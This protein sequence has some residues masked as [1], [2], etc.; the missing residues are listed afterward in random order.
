[1]KSVLVV[2]DEPGIGSLVAMCLDHLDIDVVMAN[3]KANALQA[4]RA[5]DIGL[6]LL[7]L[8][9]GSE[10]GLGILPDL[11]NEPSLAGVAIVAFTAHDSRRQEAFD[12]GVD[13][14]LKRPFSSVDLS[15]TVEAHLV[16]PP[17]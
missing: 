5:N 9:L 17:A 1:V 4:A 12:Q 2:D 16:I 13:A 10:D 15:S 6:V 14:F 8:A 7:D 3:G 11:R